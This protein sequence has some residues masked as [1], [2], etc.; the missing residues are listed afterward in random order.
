MAGRALIDREKIIEATLDL[1]REGG[2]EAVTARSLAA[3]LG[4]STMPIYSAIGSMESL[5]REALIAAFVMLNNEQKTRRTDNEALDLAI[6]YVAFARK[7]PRLFDFLMVG[8]KEIVPQI[9]KVADEGGMEGYLP[10]VA[11]VRQMLTALRAP[12]SREDFMLNTWIFT[13]G[14]A[15]LAADGLV[16]FDDEEIARHLQD[17]GG[18]FYLYELKKKEERA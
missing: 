16:D 9:L 3:R 2:W 12:E 13:H 5:K 14:L 10:D 7:E 15:Q 4:S 11:I 8:Q 18:A 17:A 1:I 6:G